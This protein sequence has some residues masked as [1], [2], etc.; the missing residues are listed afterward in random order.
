MRFL[1][2]RRRG[3]LTLLSLLAGGVAIAVGVVPSP[4]AAAGP[5]ST[6]S[7]SAPASGTVLWTAD[8]ESAVS[9]QWAEYSTNAHCA[10]TSDTVASDPEVQRVIAP[11]AQGS[12][13]YE[14]TVHD[15]DEC[16]GERAELGQA[17]PTRPG[18]SRPRLFRP[19]NDR[20]VAFQVYLAPGFPVGTPN[21][22]VIAQWKQ[23]RSTTVVPVPMV[24]IQVH[25][26]AF[27]LERAAGTAS[28]RAVTSST[29]L[30]DATPGRWVQMTMHIMFS[31]LPSV[32]FVAVY[33]DPDGTGM[34]RL[35]P[36]AHF[37]TLATNAAGDA[38][39]SAARIGIYRNP[40]IAGT[41]TLY[42]D[43][44]TVATTRAAAESVA[45]APAGPA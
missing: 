30:A 37:S 15:G 31:N 3:S 44:Y 38:V 24:T 4:P 7:A 32:G 1:L 33:G 39:P 25:D 12:H 34:R 27:Y 11:L 14:F 8:A 17:L 22:D 45:F 9:D 19:G 23:L 40:L 20:W 5:I 18:F 35:M 41:A 29:R 21:W 2:S 28:K 6:P 16:Y 10:V 42:Y 36:L 26:G 13:A 43:G